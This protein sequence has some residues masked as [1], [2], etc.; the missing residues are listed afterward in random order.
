MARAR[1]SSGGEVK[2][3]LGT[4]CE[5]KHVMGGGGQVEWAK[6]CAV[7]AS[8][9]H[10]KTT[11]ANKKTILPSGCTSAMTMSLVINSSVA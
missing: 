1:C 2:V 10:S 6:F 8:L 4:N 11:I 9:G 5:V 3:G 7:G